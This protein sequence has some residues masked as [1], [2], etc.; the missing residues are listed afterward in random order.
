M[1]ETSQEK[2]HIL[3]VDDDD[4][5][6][7]LLKKFLSE[8]DFVVSAGN[9]SA[10]ALDILDLLKFDM[11]VLDIM[12]PGEDGLV[13]TKK[14][15]Q[16]S[17]V[18]ILILS[19]MSDTADRIT[20]LEKG[21]DDY[22]VK[23]FEPKE[24][25]LRINNIIKRSK[26]SDKG[27]NILVFDEFSYDLSRKELFEKDILIKLPP[28]E[29]SILE[30]LSKTPGEMITREEIASVL[31][32]SNLRTVDV[33]ITRLRKKIEKDT[34]KPRYIQTVRGKGYALFPD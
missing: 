4:K 17:D 30:A 15:R 23:P 34:K 22:L 18:P 32:G 2:K 1:S 33:Q 26:P 3:V 14:I 6:L 11:I 8:N 9:C 16:K 21:A 5:L 24:L 12:M 20:G 13:L 27:K 29:A 19:A 7:S 10:V 28:A 25:L 31:G